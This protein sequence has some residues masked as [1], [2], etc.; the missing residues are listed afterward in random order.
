MKVLL[1]GAFGNIGTISLESLIEQGHQVRCFDL[2]TRANKKTAKRFKDQIEVVWGDLR[3]PDDVV[4]AVQDQEVVIHLAFILT[5]ASEE[6]PEWAREINVGGTHNLLNA[7]KALSRPPKI[8]F[9]STIGVFGPTQHL[10]LPRTVSDPVQPTDHYTHHKVECE[11]LVKESGLDWTIL[12]IG[13]VLPIA[14]GKIDPMMFEIPLDSRIE[15]AHPRDLGLAIANAVSCEEVWGKTLLLGGGP[16][17]Q[18]YYRAFVE[19]TL[20]VMG[21]GML[22]DQAFASTAFYLD[23]MDTTESQRLLNYQRLSFE[24]FIQEL[25]SLLGYKRYLARLFRPLARRLMLSKSP[26]FRAKS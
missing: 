4:A 5:P 10:P 14:P 11:K 3:R 6:R 23:W 8:I 22:P 15:F 9:A 7:M 17:G 1:S 24:D 26:Y 21:I 18:V 13:A 20:A 16:V 19:R 2:K 12:R 25:P